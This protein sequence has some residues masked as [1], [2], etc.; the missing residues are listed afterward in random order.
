MST[1]PFNT[2]NST[3]AGLHTLVEGLTLSPAPATQSPS[4]SIFNNP[5]RSSPSTPAST[6]GNASARPQSLSGRRT[7]YAVTVG[8]SNDS[9]VKEVDDP[10]ST[11]THA[12][13]KSQAFSR[14]FAVSSPQN[15]HGQ[16]LRCTSFRGEL[17]GSFALIAFQVGRVS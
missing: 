2:R 4:S 9:A 16:G 14:L 3:A 17:C 13:D 15:S 10:T 5:E 8:K 1:T 7:N 12:L 6:F 11:P